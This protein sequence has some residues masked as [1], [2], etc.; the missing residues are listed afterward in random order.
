MLYIHRLHNVLI[1][2]VQQ[3]LRIHHSYT[4]IPARLPRIEGASGNASEHH[5]A[6][7]SWLISCTDHTS[8]LCHVLYFSGGSPIPNG[9]TAHRLALLG[10][11]ISKLTDSQGKCLLNQTPLTSWS[12]F[13]NHIKKKNLSYSQLSRAFTTMSLHAHL[14][15]Q[16]AWM[17]RLN[18]LA[19][20]SRSNKTL[21]SRKKMCKLLH[22]MQ[23]CCA[24]CPLNAFPFHSLEINT[25]IIGVQLFN[26]TGNFRELFHCLV[27]FW[28]G[29]FNIWWLWHC[30]IWRT[31][32]LH[33]GILLSC[34][35][36]KQVNIQ[37]NKQVNN[38]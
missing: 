8:T 30:N 9:V 11:H 21:K 1:Y 38:K 22:H 34:L 37:T 26:L 5:T 35:I 36:N 27:N 24:M 31:Y 18:D 19:V 23:N 6:R 13:V 12:F 32:I 28:H 3:T 16:F 17:L 20:S 33:T 2:C 4:L 15:H 14:P 29:Y 25:L 10:N 7:S